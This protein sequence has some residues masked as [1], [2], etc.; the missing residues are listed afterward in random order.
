[1]LRVALQVAF[2]VFG[3]AAAAALTLWDNGVPEAAARRVVS[4]TAIPLA[5]MGDSNSHSYHDRLNFSVES[6]Q[7]GGVNQDRTFNWVEV[8]A[9]LRG[10]E[11]DLGPWV[12]WGRSGVIVRL[13]DLLHLPVGRAPRKEDYLYNFAFSAMGCEQLMQ[14]KYRQAP[15]L[16]ALMDREPE[17]WRHGVVVIRTGL[18]EWSQFMDQ[19]AKDPNAPE[20]QPVI[21]GCVKHIGDAIAL[22]H[23]RH[24][25]TRV[26]VV[27]VVNEAS[28]PLYFDRWQSG[29]EFRNI[30]KALGRLN[31]ALRQ[32]A[33]AHANTIF[34]DDQAWV[35][36]R[37][38][39]RDADGMPA[40][41]TVTVGG[42]LQVTNTAGN[43]PTH[44]IMEDHH[45]GL[46]YNALW[47]QSLIER[48][49]AGFGLTITPI[50]E[51]ELARFVLPLAE[52]S[53][54]TALR[55]PGS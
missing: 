55:A 52:A 9:R 4:P 11:L 1:M 40:Y 2:V 50:G 26:V 12:T 53:L 30:E 44:A 31:G 33:Q 28:D 36:E 17:R 6:G 34:F 25:A 15:R 41:R 32:L 3:T 27:G 18:G 54:G 22:I 37:W 51:P 48:L 8:L 45:S 24:P 42:K 47:A 10:E 5:V 16:V 46:A 7:R 21:D 39:S 38:G 35:L 29:V 13:L 23:T 19:Q 43:E 14:G 20:L 49:N